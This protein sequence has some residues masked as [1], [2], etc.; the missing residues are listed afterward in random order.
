MHALRNLFRQKTRSL[1]T[2]FG[3]TIGVAAVVALGSV[4]NGMAGGYDSLVGN[5]GQADLVVMQEGS[6]DLMMSLVDESVADELAA[7]PEIRSVSKIMY[8]WVG[9]G[10]ALYFGLFGYDPDEEAIG[11][12]CIVD[13]ETLSRRSHDVLLGATL[14]RNLKKGVGDTVVVLGVSYKVRGVYETG[15]AF[16]DAGMIA[17][18]RTAQEMMGRTRQVSG[19][20]LRLRSPDD[21][22]SA[23]QRIARRH[24]DLSIAR[25]SE[26]GDQTVMIQAFRAMGWG[27]SMLAILIGGVTMT[28]TI[29]MSVYERTR[30][31][32]VLRAIGWRKGRVLRMFLTESS[33]LALIG[34]ALGVGLGAF[35]IWWAGTSPAF[36]SILTGEVTS[37]LIAQGMI[38]ALVLGLVGG[39][40]PAWQASRLTPLVALSHEGGAAGGLPD[41][42][43]TRRLG[44]TV[45]GLLRRRVRTLLTILG[46]AI[47]IAAI[48]SLTS[49]VDGTMSSLDAMFGGAELVA[50]QAG[51]SDTSFSTISES[52][53]RR[54]AAM[55]GVS[56][57]EGM[58]FSAVQIPKQGFLLIMGSHPA[59]L[60]ARHYTIIDGEPMKAGRDMILGRMAAENLDKSVGDTIRLTGTTFRIVGIYETGQGWEDGGAVITLR[61]AQR[62]FGKP[63]QVT[64]LSIKVEYPSQAEQ[65]RDRLQAAFPDLRIGLSAEF[66]DESSDM[67]SMN[68]MMGMISF[69]AIFVGGLGM[70]NTMVMS[71]ME[72]TREIGLL[73][74]VGWSRRRTLWLIMR[75]S[76]VLGLIGGLAGLALGVFLAWGLSLMPVADAFVTPAYGTNLLVLSIAI[77]LGLGA[78]GGLYPAWRATR[79]RPIEALQYE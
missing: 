75:E 6:Y 22:E 53:A 39:A 48:V 17:D 24:S 57:V 31:I 33:L 13:G 51:V 73:R 74:A 52:D 38:T 5:R 34:G 44:P 35:L 4:A 10:E 12:I 66:M 55:P 56:S 19:L 65:V 64:F 37:D 72:R 77:A 1:L 11:K 61:E 50:A 67:Q 36:G 15:D 27:I 58:V 54:M 14:A 78:V 7:M 59:S 79:L 71:V 26:F 68:A 45:R 32:G 3:V 9:S 16:R 29:I 8:S 25:T 60:G 30:E 23:R 18:I 41:N 76:L 69:L 21:E 46:T 70:M 63:R 28:N 49:I 42:A 43:V 40:L 20:L 2:L 62:L 47:G